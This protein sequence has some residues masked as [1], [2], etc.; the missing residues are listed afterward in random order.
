MFNLSN[1]INS[2]FITAITIVFTLLYFS[3]VNS[4]PLSDDFAD[5][6]GSL[7]PSVVNVFTVQKPKK[8]ENNQIPFD[9]IP[10]QF[11]DFFKNFPPGFPF[12]PQPGPQQQPEQ[13]R[14]QATV[15]G[16]ILVKRSQQL[17]Q[18]KFQPQE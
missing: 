15:F 6:V 3:R 13:E 4:H 10:P 7:S 16:L 17:V 18:S 2:R 14:P 8:I 11:R 5:L 1:H 9:N 12:G